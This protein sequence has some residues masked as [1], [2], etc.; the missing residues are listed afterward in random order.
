MCTLA[1]MDYD[2]Y[3]AT[4]N[5]EADGSATQEYYVKP[6]WGHPWDEARAGKLAAM[7]RA[8]IQRRFPK[9]PAPNQ[10]HVSC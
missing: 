2:V 9:V 3:H 6:R 7:L 4:I 1:D 10:S 5:S 8:A